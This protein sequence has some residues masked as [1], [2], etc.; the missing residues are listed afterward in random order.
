M[1]ITIYLPHYSC[2]LS[3]IPVRPKCSVSSVLIAPGPCGKTAQRHKEYLDTIDIF[4]E[5]QHRTVDGSHSGHTLKV[6]TVAGSAPVI[7]REGERRQTHSDRSKHRSLARKRPCRQNSLT[8]CS[9]KDEQA[10]SLQ[11]KM[12]TAP[13][14]GECLQPAPSRVTEVNKV[15]EIITQDMNNS[16]LQNMNIQNEA[17]SE[18]LNVVTNQQEDK[19]QDS[20]VCEA[21]QDGNTLPDKMNHSEKEQASLPSQSFSPN[22]KIQRR[23]RVYKRKRRKVDTRAERVKQSNI[24]GDSMMKLWQ[25]FHSSDDMDVEFLGFE[26]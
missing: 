8:S 24:P 22:R 7:H 16:P 14:S 25:L 17:S 11:P 4:K 6:R 5:E 12:E 20:S 3:L 15:D 23:V 9:H 21:V 1:K 10:Q 18:C 2:N 26:D 19:K 13:S